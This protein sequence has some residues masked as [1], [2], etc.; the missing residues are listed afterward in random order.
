MVNC[1]F[2]MNRLYEF[3]KDRIF[4]TDK[5]DANSI[6]T[7]LYLAGEIDSDR[8][9]SEEESKKILSR[10]PRTKE[11]GLG[12]LALWEK[13]G[14]LL[15]AGVISLENPFHITHRINKKDPFCILYGPSERDFL[16]YS[17]LDTISYHMLKH[18]R[19]EPTYRIPNKLLNMEK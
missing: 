7:A 4:K 17:D 14:E 18:T 13:G 16:A 11:P 12:Y 8:Y 19:I 3:I 10:M 15:H 9:V 1:L 2:F 6:G 5:K